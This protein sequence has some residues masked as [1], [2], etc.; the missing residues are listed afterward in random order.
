MINEFFKSKD[1]KFL[2]LI[3]ALLLIGRPEIDYAPLFEKI[4]GVTEQLIIVKGMD[5]FFR[6][7]N[8]PRWRKKN[9]LI[10]GG[11]GAA[12]GNFDTLAEHKKFID[13]RASFVSGQI[14]EV[15]SHPRQKVESDFDS[16]GLS[17][18]FIVSDLSPIPNQTGTKLI[19][20]YIVGLSGS[21]DISKITI[22]FTFEET[23]AQVGGVS[24]SS[25]RC[26]DFDIHERIR[27]EYKWL[28]EES[29]NKI[30]VDKTL[31]KS[32][33]ES[34]IIDVRELLIQHEFDCAVSFTYFSTPVTAAI[35]RLFPVV[36]VPIQISLPP[37]FRPSIQCV[38]SHDPRLSKRNRAGDIFVIERQITYPLVEQSAIGC[39]RVRNTSREVIIVCAAVDIDLRVPPEN[40]RAFFGV[41]ENALKNSSL[42]KFVLVGTPVERAETIFSFFTDP[43]AVKAKV[44]IVSYEPN[45]VG[46]INQCD[47]FVMPAHR[48]GG[49]SIRTA[50][51][52]GLVVL[53]LDENDGNL[54]MPPDFIFENEISLGK[55][56]LNLVT[57][58]LFLQQA[59]DRSLGYFQTLD[60]HSVVSR[61][62]M[63][64]REAIKRFR[65][66]KVL[67]LGDSHASV[68]LKE[69][70]SSTIPDTILEVVCA[71]GATL[72]GLEN[73][74]SATQ[75]GA[76]FTYALSEAHWDMVIFL[77]GE[78]DLGYVIWFRSERDGGS[79]NE[80]AQR[81]LDNY[82]KLI[83]STLDSKQK[84]VVISAPL[85]TISDGNK[86]GEVAQTRS[87]I[88]A[89]QA[90]R[91]KLT[92]WFNQQMKSWC[93]QYDGLYF[94]DLDND[95][96]GVDGIVS[97][98][99]CHPN[100]KDHH[101]D[102]GQ[103]KRLLDKHLVP[104][105]INAIQH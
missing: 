82:Q 80:A 26:R 71:H 3:S 102:S 17:I 62:V 14:A 36:Y 57:D 27:T 52:E 31:K 2:Q 55:C 63:A 67:V 28:S 48:G 64:C 24:L 81:A 95:S 103:Y 44:N 46:L 69:D 35:A 56:L 12:L 97:K 49:R 47:I 20:D 68:F 4:S 37:K 73:P 60:N 90:D 105:V 39:V 42:A 22:L 19:L 15:I 91:T 93:A 94:I 5:G 78:V 77:M 85:P 101:Y 89:S 30:S 25:F 74:N 40:L 41:I 45:F 83:K 58:T 61:F 88:K 23:V 7:L 33:P 43:E 86:A 21:N 70:F 8:N 54:Y 99:L 96:L 11:G 50:L 10:E 13:R 51:H 72:S 75:A 9:E 53:A 66:N 29:I 32:T 18:M 79:V 1:Q 65:M 100:A 38:M 59:K 6:T 104:V 16:V 84:A 92:M 87:G 76:K 34:Y 98:D